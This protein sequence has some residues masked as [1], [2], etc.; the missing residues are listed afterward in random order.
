[1]RKKRA[2]AALALAAM[3]GGCSD[4]HP[5]EPRDRFA[6]PTNLAARFEWTF[7]GWSSGNRA[8]GAPSVALSWD[9]PSGW[10]G[11]PFRIYGR[12]TGQ[13]SYLLMATATSCASSRCVYTDVNVAPGQSYDYYVTAVDERENRESEASKAVRVAVP[14]ASA[15]VAPRAPS[16]VALDDALYLRWQGTGSGA[17]WKYQVWLLAVDG[18]TN[19]PYQ[20]GETDGVGFLD[21]RAENGHSYTY[22]IAAVDT[23][24]RVSDLS[25]AVV[26]TPRPDA[27]G[28]LVYAFGDNGAQSGF[29]FGASGN[30]VMSGS[31]AQAQWRLEVVGGNLSIRP[32]GE[33]QVTAGSF[34]SALTCGPASDPGCTSVDRA[35]TSGYGTA[36][37]PLDAEFTYVLKVRGDDGRT[38]YGKV[39]VQ[40]LGSD[41]SGRRLAIL[42]WAYQLRADE[43]SLSVQPVM[44]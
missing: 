21:L 28:V 24:G 33:T 6:A 26:G 32:L 36:A 7:E 41:Q 18:Q 2:W 8:V 25:D 44:R 1:M 16:V 3:L 10:S 20:V 27:Y 34:T 30:P 12:R 17:L 9:L 43:A 31:A 19:A 29:R 11:G 23:L 37:V 15:P 22:R 5:T 4:E 40:L 38:H 39:R 35:P 42:D 14:S 13:S